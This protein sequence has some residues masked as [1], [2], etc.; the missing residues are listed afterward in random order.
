MSDQL[1]RRLEQTLSGRA[2]TIAGPRFTA[3]DL[4]AAGRGLRARRRRMAIAGAGIAVVA[5]ITATTL[6]G[7]KGLLSGQAQVT[8]ATRGPSPSGNEVPRRIPAGEVGLDV[9]ADGRLFPHDGSPRELGL[10]AGEDPRQAIRTPD[11]WLIE[12]QAEATGGGLWFVRS[13]GEPIRIGSLSG[14]FAVSPDGRTLAADGAVE[15]D[16][17]TA[18]ELPSLRQIR[19]VRNT[20]GPITLGVSGDWAVVKDVSGDPSPT[21]AYA[22]NYRTGEL[23]PTE[24]PINVWGV[25]ADGRVLRRVIDDSATTPRT[26]CVD[27]V[28]IGALS[29]VGASGYCGVE[30]GN[31]DMGGLISSDGAWAVLH[32]GVQEL[33]L[34]RTADLRNG[35]WQPVGAGFPAD[36][37]P[38][39]W[40]TDS[41][42]VVADRV[43]RAYYYCR[44]LD[45]CQPL[46]VPGQSRQGL[47]IVPE[48]G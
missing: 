35:T 27:L 34:V 22:W 32:L 45:P 19:S 2:A 44:P 12:T 39:F 24:K 36:V 43:A 23:R 17:V 13:G 4:I 15:P 42:L 33:V 38:L 3:N 28:E 8:P 40:T 6:L 7:A 48:V 1:E 25:T 10:P 16:L 29:P 37:D 46:A 41:A 20:A 26:G 5:V 14:T 11:G 18:Y 21:T 47:V 9:I 30:V 31:A